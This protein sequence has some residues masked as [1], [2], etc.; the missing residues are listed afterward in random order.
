MVEF[1]SIIPPGQV[2]ELTQQIKLSKLS[3]GPFTK[4]VNVTSNAENIEVLRVSIT[5]KI[6]SDIHLSHKFIHL[7]PATTRKFAGSLTLSTEKKDFKIEEI[8]F[9]LKGKKDTP[10]WQFDPEI[11]FNYSMTTSDT[12]DADGYY[13]Y[14]LNFSCTINPPP[15]ILSGSFIFKTNHPKRETIELR[16]MINPKKD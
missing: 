4:S 13:T 15:E 6:L 11:T 14:S 10:E 7:K 1:D 16:G 12:A 9:K 8:S 5:G 3:S 2:G